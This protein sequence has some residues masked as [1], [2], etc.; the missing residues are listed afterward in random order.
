MKLLAATLAIA[1]ALIAQATRDFLTADEVDQIRVTAQ[2]PNERLKLYTTFARTRV[3]M[4]K[5]LLAKEKAGRSAIVH[6][7]LEEYTK[8]IEAI[9]TVSDDSLRHGKEIEEGTKAVAAAEKEMLATLEEVRGQQP[10]DLDR[11][12]FALLTAIETTQDSIELSQADLAQRKHDSVSK[13]ADEKKKREELMTPV[14]AKERRE[15]SRKTAETETKA[16][17]KAPTLRRKGESPKQ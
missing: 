10:K 9:D 16:A 13:A 12:K 3:D 6:Q 5:S 4:V 2:E 1:S 15:A 7:T 8:I 14:D 17:K 11:Y